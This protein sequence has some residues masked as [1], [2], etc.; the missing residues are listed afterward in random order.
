MPHVDY[1]HAPL[2]RV[3]KLGSKRR[4]DTAG[5]FLETDMRAIKRKLIVK[6]EGLENQGR[7]RTKR[8]KAM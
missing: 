7:T 5:E 6:I 2:E 8:M 1:S 4:R 3:W